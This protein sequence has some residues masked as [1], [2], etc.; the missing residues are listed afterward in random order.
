M[1]ANL[2][3]RAREGTNVTRFTSPPAQAVLEKIGLFGEYDIDS[4]RLFLNF[5]IGVRSSYD[6]TSPFAPPDP[7]YVSSL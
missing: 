5:S 6:R 7:V 2:A 3:S 4:S 1:D